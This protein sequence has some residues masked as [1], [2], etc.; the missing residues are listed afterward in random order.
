MTALGRPAKDLIPDGLKR[1]NQ[2]KNLKR[3]HPSAIPENEKLRP[4]EARFVWLLAEKGLSP[5]AAWQEV[6][7]AAPQHG[8]RVIKKPNVLKALLEARE[9]WAVASRMT[10]QRCIDG[11]LESI[12]LAKMAGEPIAM[13]AAWR[14][15]ARMCGFYEPTKHKVEISVNGQLQLERLQAIPREELL[16]LVDQPAIEGEFAALEG[17]LAP[18]PPTSS[19]TSDRVDKNDPVERALGRAS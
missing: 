8:Y 4:D 12:N 11:F 6:T 7:G 14:E 17:P 16:K 15:I 18:T 9:K 10:R 13:V 2:L 1:L 5:G 19:S 3:R